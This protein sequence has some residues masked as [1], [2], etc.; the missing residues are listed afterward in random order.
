M[1]EDPGTAVAV[2]YVHGQQVAHSFLASLMGLVGYDAA[3]HGRV[4]RGGYVAVRCGTNQLPAAR[5]TM[6]RVFLSDREADWLLVLDT[7]MGFGPDTVDRLY[8]A[9][10]PVARPIVGAL[11]FANR[12]LGQD[13]M[14]GYRTVAEPTVLD[15][16]EHE[17]RRGFAVRF[18]YP[19]DTVTR[20]AGTGMACVLMHRGVL[21]KIGAE[22]GTW[23]EQARDPAAGEL[24]GEDLSFYLRAGSLEIPVHV[25]TGVRTTHA[26]TVWL[27][28]P[29]YRLQRVF[30]PG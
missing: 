25:H 11:C 13:G 21:E 29:D 30:L 18:D 23:F 2:G 22:Y 27:G 8:E 24:L 1:T 15:W 19:R 28:E 10:D 3:H 14:G 4:W 7:D 26:K 12:E 9:A 20:V 5:N 6:V 17:G 16:L